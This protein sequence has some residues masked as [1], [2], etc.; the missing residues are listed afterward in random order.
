MHFLH[1]ANTDGWAK[2]IQYV[3]V[4]QTERYISQPT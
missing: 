4:L 3:K 1:L 2:C